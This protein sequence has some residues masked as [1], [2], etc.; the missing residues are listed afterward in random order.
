MR[1][2]KTSVVKIGLFV[3]TNL[4]LFFV[5]APL[6]PNPIFVG[7]VVAG[8][9]LVDYLTDSHESGGLRVFAFWPRRKP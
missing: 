3:V 8:G 4:I 9:S 7:L 5:V 1:L 2:M 6:V